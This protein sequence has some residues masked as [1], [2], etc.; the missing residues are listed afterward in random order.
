[1][2]ARFRKERAVDLSCPGKVRH[3]KCFF[4]SLYA[5]GETDEYVKA[6]ELRY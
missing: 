1:M 3:P 6:A 5:G 2:T 4:D